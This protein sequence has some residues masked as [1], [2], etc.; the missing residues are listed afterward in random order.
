MSLLSNRDLS[1]AKE[2]VQTGPKQDKVSG[3]SDCEVHTDQRQLSFVKKRN[4]CLPV[5]E[6]LSCSCPV[7]AR[8]SKHGT[9]LPSPAG[10]YSISFSGA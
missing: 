8:L 2:T 3:Q 6:S 4:Y 7:E 9:A 10:P 5:S 1:L